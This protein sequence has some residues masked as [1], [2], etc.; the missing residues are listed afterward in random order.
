LKYGQTGTN[1]DIFVHDWTLI[2]SNIKE[3]ACGDFHSI[4]LSNTNKV[5]GF[6]NNNLGQLGSP[7]LSIIKIPQLINLPV[8]D[9]ICTGEKFTV[10]LT[11]NSLLYS[12]GDNS[13]GQLGLGI[14]DPYIQTPTKIPIQFSNILDI[15]CGYY[16]FM[17]LEKN[18]SVFSTGLNNVIL[19]IKLVWTIRYF[20]N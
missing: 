16:H 19:L 15:K 10:I 7:V 5:Y 8:T 9:K 20:N 1:I 4:V 3:I 2:L 12:F 18:G 11:N 6:G 14:S 13:F 17:V